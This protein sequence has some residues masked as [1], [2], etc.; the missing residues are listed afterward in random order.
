MDYVKLYDIQLFLKTDK[1]NNYEVQFTCYTQ[2]TTHGFRHIC[3]LGY[4]DTTE[5]RLIKNDIVA[6][7]TYLNRTWENYQY[8]TVLRNAVRK[9]DIDKNI[10][11]NL[12]AKI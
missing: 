4:S 2:D 12:L 6:K 8:Q 11:E 9:L 5:S 10:K 3:T 1:E 7:V